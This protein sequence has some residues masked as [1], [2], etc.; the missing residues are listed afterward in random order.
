MAVC[1]QQV[2][3]DPIEL[4]VDGAATSNVFQFTVTRIVGGFITEGEVRDSAGNTTPLGGTCFP[5]LMTPEVSRMSFDFNVTGRTGSVVRV[6]LAGVGR[7][8]NGV[9]LKPVFIG[10]FV[11]L[12][13]IA[14]AAS[15]LPS[16][17]LVDPG[18][19]GT[20]SGTQ[21]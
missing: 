16:P 9:G 4:F 20:G 14:G 10:R 12:A 19:T 11:A 13:P 15:G 17:T 3:W 1:A 21:T 6:F 7:Q 18:D 8:P 5:V 2:T